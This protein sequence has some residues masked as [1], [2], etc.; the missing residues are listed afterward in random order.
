ML[1]GQLKGEYALMTLYDALIE[2]QSD[3]ERCTKDSFSL[4]FKYVG[5]AA[6]RKMLKVR[7]FPRLQQLIAGTLPQNSD[8]QTEAPLPEPLTHSASVLTV[9]PADPSEPKPDE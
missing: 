6:E 4:L 2:L 7:Y 3:S 1:L 5:W 8:R 9:M